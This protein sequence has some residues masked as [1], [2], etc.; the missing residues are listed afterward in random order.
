MR[1]PLPWSQQEMM[2]AWSWG[3]QYRRGEVV[4]LRVKTR[5]VSGLN[6]VDEEREDSRVTDVSDLKLDQ[7][8]PHF[9]NGGGWFLCSYEDESLTELG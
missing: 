2:V 1:S 9:S 5:R 6:A 4:I 7:S 3:L 8:Q